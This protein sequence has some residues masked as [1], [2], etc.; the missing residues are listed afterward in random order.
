M[1]LINFISIWVLLP[2]LTFSQNSSELETKKGFKEIKLL[3]N[4]STVKTS[5]VNRGNGAAR[6]RYA[7]DSKTVYNVAI[8]DIF[9]ETDGSDLIRKIRIFMPTVSDEI[10][11]S[12][13]KQIKNDFGTPCFTYSKENSGSGSLAWKTDK[14]YMEY[15][16]EYSSWGKWKPV[17]NIGLLMDLPPEIRKIYENPKDGF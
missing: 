7:G 3:N 15:S 11:F 10:F 16:W 4:I 5:D 13:S 17:V 9:I 14:L 1:R 2:T 6:Y 12:L 8:E